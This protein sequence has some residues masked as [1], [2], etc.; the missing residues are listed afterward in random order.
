MPW[1]FR[2]WTTSLPVDRVPQSINAVLS[3]CS[4]KKESAWPTS[5]IVSSKVPSTDWIVSVDFSCSSAF[6]FGSSFGLLSSWTS[7]FEY[8]FGLLSAWTYGLGSSLGLL[9]FDF[10]SFLIANTVANARIIIVA[11]ILPC[12]FRPFLSFDT[13]DTSLKVLLFYYST[14]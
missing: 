4:K 10:K 12:S 2:Y 14:N 3:P 6:C 7:G 9:S 1:S 5:I 13:Y 8:S 11:S